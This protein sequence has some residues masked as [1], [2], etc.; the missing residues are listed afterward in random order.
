M[1]KYYVHEL[2]NGKS[3]LLGEILTESNDAMTISKQVK[4]KFPNLTNFSISS[5]KRLNL[6]KGN[7]KNIFL[8]GGGDYVAPKVNF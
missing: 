1:N 3:E 2:I 7:N 4:A 6:S 8:G 5:R